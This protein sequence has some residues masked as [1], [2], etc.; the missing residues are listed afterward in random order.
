MRIIALRV[1]FVRDTLSTTTGD[2]S[3]DY[4]SND[5]VYFDPPPRDADYFAYH[6]EFQRFYWGK[7][8]GDAVHLE[9]EIFPAKSDSAYRL[10]KQM[11][12]YNYN[13]G[14]AQLD[15]GL[16]MLFRDAV[17]AAD[18]DS[19]VHWASD[20]LV[21]VFHAGA[22]AEFDLG[23][24]STPHDIPSA[25]MVQ[26]DFRRQLNLPSGIPVDGDSGFV[27][28]GL[29]LP[30]TESHEGVQISMAGV[31]TLMI[32]HWL[33]LP[34]LYDKDD[35]NPVVGKWSMMDRAFGNF[36]GAIPG[37]VDAWSKGYMGW[38]P[39]PDAI[40]GDIRLKASGVNDATAVEACRIPISDTE[41]FVLEVRDRDPE[42]DSVAVAYDRAGRR[43]VFHEDYSVTADR[44]FRVPISVDNLDFDS[45]GSGILIWHADEGLRSLVAEG[46]FNSVNGARGLD[47]EEADGAQDIG[48]NYPILTPGYGTDYGVFEDAWY[49]DNS[50]YSAANGGRQVSFNDDSYPNS[51]AN[52]GA[53]TH[54]A[55]DSLSRQGGVM[56]VRLQRE[57]FLFN[58]PANLRPHQYQLCGGNFDNDPTTPEF[59]LIWADS[60][61]FY[62]LLGEVLQRVRWPNPQ[63]FIPTNPVVRNLNGGPD[64]VVWFDAAGGHLFS[65][66]SNILGGY[67]YQS[68]S[69]G[70]TGRSRY[71]FGG[72]E[73]GTV[74]AAVDEGNPCTG[75]RFNVTL[76]VVSAVP[77]PGRVTSLHRFGSAHSDTFVVVLSSGEAF[78]WTGGGTNRIVKFPLPPAGI[79]DFSLLADFNGDGEQ[80]LAA[81]WTDSDATGRWMTLATARGPL[82]APYPRADIHDL[83]RFVSLSHPVAV[84]V[85]G[86]GRFEIL[87]YRLA[88]RTATGAVNPL[89]ALNPNGTLADGFPWP[90]EDAELSGA[91]S[92]NS[93]GDF[94]GDGRL[95]YLISVSRSTPTDDS[96]HPAFVVHRAID[97]R[98]EG[99]K[100][101]PDFPMVAAS[102]KP[103]VIVAGDSGVVLLI[104]STTALRGLFVP[105]QSGGRPAIWWQGTY[106]D[107]DHSNAIWE[108]AVPFSP[109]LSAPLMPSDL[110]YNWP[111]PARGSTA[112]RYFLNQPAVVRVEIFDIAGDRVASLTGPGTAGLPNEIVWNVRDVARG[113]YLAVVEAKGAGK[114]E[115]KTVKIAVLK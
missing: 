8:S 92:P 66:T 11:W 85:N 78:L 51:R 55:L 7:M 47:L 25:W 50:A 102:Q 44:G 68:R 69:E 99:G 52:S 91:D 109:A 81:I 10:P 24:S 21:I 70:A 27:T 40:P 22:G 112:I 30:E 108:P 46:R 96:L 95:D 43:M 79:V 26:D 45:P 1:E 59:A 34:A 106:R 38:L 16:A 13:G 75:T 15:S 57:R 37:P 36:Y 64:D 100:S 62:N 4:A 17:E 87:G 83:V 53:F 63:G 29:I 33:G 31:V 35:G 9:W 98:S 97:L 12:Q 58:I 86:D 113:G 76:D 71:A 72:S 67:D 115:R 6:L 103:F 20:K 60:A 39:I 82:A 80:D 2:G 23:F 18:R 3:F 84:D 94:N 61:V 89:V 105:A 104:P 73:F 101:L 114:T 48:R 107:N 14:A 111:N 74:L 56:T 88:S 90:N 54:V 49:G 41:A 77:F 32:G 110:C 28:G 65:L 42:S 93:M 5:T 19:T